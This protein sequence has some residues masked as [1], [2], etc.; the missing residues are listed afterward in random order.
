MSRIRILASVALAGLALLAAPAARATLVVLAPHPDDGEAS[1]GGLIAN[2]AAAG[3][4]VVVVCMTGGEL[5]VYG[6]PHD[7]ARA[8]RTE[9]ARRAAAALG[10]GSLMFGGLDGSLAVDAATTARLRELLLR[11]RPRAVAAPWPLDVHPDHQATGVLAWRVSMDRALD[12]DL[13]F[14]ETTNSPHTMSSGFVPTDYVDITAVLD[15]KRAATLQ[16]ASQGPA[17]WFGM[18]VDLARVRGFEADVPYAEGY[19]RARNGSGLGGRS[20]AVGRTLPETR[21]R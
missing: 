18:Y 16:H 2:T 1:C 4:S 21:A 17:D 13:Y 20:G 3:E 11:L 12:F 9:E 19:V 8:V 7:Q 10:A 6:K 5:A 14:Y 15:R